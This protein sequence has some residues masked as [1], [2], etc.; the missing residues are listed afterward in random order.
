MVRY[1]ILYFYT[2]I[3]LIISIRFFLL[4]SWDVI[5]NIMCNSNML[6]L[7]I[8]VCK[9][10]WTLRTFL[11]YSTYKHKISYTD[12]KKYMQQIN[13]YRYCIINFIYVQKNHVYTYVP[14][15]YRI[16]IWRIKIS[17]RLNF[18]LHSLHSYEFKT[19][20]IIYIIVYIG[21]RSCNSK[22]LMN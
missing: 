7:A 13:R 12:I 14:T 10:F 18:R 15:T 1:L 4:N 20:K 21:T 17:L 6:R 16:S 11:K 2:N 9:Y 5:Y 8:F 19:N 3:Y 22:M